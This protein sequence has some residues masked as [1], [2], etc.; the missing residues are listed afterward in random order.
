M[1][2]VIRLAWVTARPAR[3]LDDDEPLALRALAERGARVDVVDW[4]DHDVAWDSYDRV[5]VRSTWDYVERLP[6]FAAW[7]EA[8]EATGNL[9]NPAAMMRWSLDKHYLADLAAA[10]IPIV[11]TAYCEPGEDPAFPIDNVVVK[12]AVGAGSR[13]AAW[14]PPTQHDLGRRHVADLHARGRSVLIQ[15]LLPSVAAE[16]EW[17]LVFFGG[18]F[19]HAANKRVRLP[20]AALLEDFFAPQVIAGCDPDGDQIAV[21]QAVVDYVVA[22]FGV[23]TYAQVDLVR[24]E[25]GRACVLEVELVEPSLFLSQAD[26][27]APHRL[28]D[29]I[30]T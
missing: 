10:D 28:A 25:A 29:A 18:R 9:R 4:D 19:S 8:V 12:P 6:Q 27:G 23:P 2:A 14:Y 21:G 22:R 16:G 7:M 26:G 5:V 17:P 30:V 1:T 15:P 13:D 20:H 24:D 11:A 3:G